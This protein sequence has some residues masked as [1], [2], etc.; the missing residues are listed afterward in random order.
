M[1]KSM[2]EGDDTKNLPCGMNRVNR[3]ER[4]HFWQ[5]KINHPACKELRPKLY[6]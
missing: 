4:F 6:K 2:M 3:F 5:N 1:E